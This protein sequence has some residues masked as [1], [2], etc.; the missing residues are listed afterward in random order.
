LLEKVGSGPITSFRAGSFAANAD[1]F[2]ALRRNG[3]M[4]DSSL[5]S[6]YSV[7]GTDLR[8]QHLFDSPFN[9]NEVYTYPVTV[10][11]DGT[12]RDRPAH[13][14]ACSF[15]EMKD[16]LCSARTGGMSDFVLVSHNF[17]M[18]RPGS[19][20]PAWIVVR[21][22]EQLCAY[23]A[24]HRDTLPV[25]GYAPAQLRQTTVNA[26]PK[27]ST[28]LVSTLRRHVEQLLCRIA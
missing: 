27:P 16:A 24:A 14:G 23:L 7:S 4:I 11:K 15:E 8:N 3:I 25:G 5:N 2:E 13:V 10:F 9:I 17:E 12:G 18:L 26:V 28:R 1:T 20:E 22:F 19:S 21:R 6:C